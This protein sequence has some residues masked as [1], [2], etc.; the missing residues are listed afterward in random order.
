VGRPVRRWAAG[1]GHPAGFGGRVLISV[2]ATLVLVLVIF[3]PSAAARLAARGRPPWPA[4]SPAQLAAGV[5][6]AGLTLLPA[7]G[8]VTRYAVHLDV[9]VDGK[10]VT[11]P[12]GIGLDYRGRRIAA[13]YTSGT[14][15]VVHV[16]SDAERSV[17]TLGQFF[18]EWQVALT[19][20]RLGGLGEV[21]GAV[22]NAGAEARNA[23]DDVVAVYVDGARVA[24]LPGSVRLTPQ[25]EIAV[26][27]RPGQRPVPARYAFPA[28]T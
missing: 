18:D 14:S 24:G 1:L 8:V 23:R 12:A 28:G 21:G 15:G 10:R 19:P 26:T 22:Q 3:S 6:A 27:Y 11:V 25:L 9:I 2:T 4:P 20:D 13:L 16:D 5:H 17:F 7:P